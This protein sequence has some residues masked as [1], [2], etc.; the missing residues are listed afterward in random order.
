MVVMVD[1]VAEL[2]RSVAGYKSAAEREKH[3]ILSEMLR[4][5]SERLDEI[6][7]AIDRQITDEMRDQEYDAPEGFEFS[8]NLTAEQVSDINA[9]VLRLQKIAKDADPR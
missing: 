7:G 1:H 9:L 3:W 4:D 2:D 8:V 5:I 6:N